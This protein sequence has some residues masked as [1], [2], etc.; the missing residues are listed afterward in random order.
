MS[1]VYRLPPPARVVFV[2]IDIDGQKG[3][4]NNGQKKIRAQEIGYTAWRPYTWLPPVSGSFF[5]PSQGVEP[6]RPTYETKR[7]HGMPFHFTV[8]DV[9]ASGATGTCFPAGVVGEILAIRAIEALPICQGATIVW[10]YKGG[11]CEVAL[12]EA[13]GISAFDVYNLENW[14]CPSIKNLEENGVVFMP[15]CG[16]HQPVRP[17]VGGTK[18]N[19]IF[20]ETLVEVTHCPRGETAAFMDWARSNRVFFPRFGNFL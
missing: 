9:V 8:K 12:F 18:K 7:L 17:K 16:M 14:N 13:A 6:K 20:S 2:V 5:F 15:Q 1:T 19:P 11:D 4:Y 3:N 10:L